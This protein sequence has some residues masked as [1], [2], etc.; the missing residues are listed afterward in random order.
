MCILFFHAKKIASPGKF[1][2]ILVSNRDE[3]LKRPTK[4]A[5]FWAECPDIFGGR[6]LQVSAEGGTWLAVNSKSG[7]L[8]TLLNL[9]TK[10]L[11]PNAISR[12]NIVT[13]FVKDPSISGRE[14]EAKVAEKADQHNPFHLV[15][16]EIL[17][18]DVLINYLAHLPSGGS[19]GPIDLLQTDEVTESISNSPLPTPMNKCKEGL[20][21]FKEVIGKLDSTECKRELIEQLIS[22]AKTDTKFWPDPI[23]SMRGELEPLLK[24][25]SS[26]F[27]NVP[28]KVYGT[29]THT[30]ILIDDVG[31]MDFYESTLTENSKGDLEWLDTHQTFDFNY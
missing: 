9:S 30:V 10:T 23:L 24:S 12:G 5:H 7:R 14:Y 1:R 22:F 25:Y 15:T 29:R 21:L 18:N 8:A 16:F 2:L 27:V 20:K 6:D 28:E 4:H 19:M 3:S 11:N 13:D 31:K 26:I 17:P